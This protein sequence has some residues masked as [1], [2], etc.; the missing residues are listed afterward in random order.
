MKNTSKNI[1]PLLLLFMAAGLFGCAHRGP[2]SAYQG[3]YENRLAD[4]RVPS[5]EEITSVKESEGNVVLGQP[6]QKVWDACLG[7]AAQSKGIL[8]V[9]DDVG[10]VHRLL[11]LSGK[12]VEYKRDLWLFV[13][14]WLAISIRPLA[15]RSTEVRIVFVSPETGRV[16]PFAADRFPRGFK[17]DAKESISQVTGE[18]LIW[19]LTKTF[20]EDDYLSRLSYSKHIARGAPQKIDVKQMEHH[21]SLAQ[22]LGN[23]QSASIRRER[24]VLNEPR[25][26]ERIAAVVRD[27]ARAAGELN[28]ETRIFVI[29][30]ALEAT[31][32]EPNGDVFLTIGT[33]DRIENVDE[34][35]GVLSHELAHLY[36]HH[37]AMR[38]GASRRA[39]ATRN[40]AI[41]IGTLGGAIAGGLLPTKK[42]NSPQAPQDT[43][44]STREV[45]I[46]A[47]V[48]YGAMHF[49]GQIGTSVGVDVGGYTIYRFSQKEELVADNYGAEL[50]WAAGY[51]YRGFLKFLQK[52]N[53]AWLFEAGAKKRR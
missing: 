43:L 9:A 24:F 49:G 35:A 39:A 7:L 45:L 42:P 47:A 10:G 18:D 4:V 17:G 1:A 34:L 31:H 26:E 15:E 6:S 14:R 51:D 32:V 28:R 38:F 30:D 29:A 3:F 33:L 25:L 52:Q 11:L 48:G 41:F 27:I 13:D 46:G 2:R 37:G 22:Q 8:G 12:N 44:L 50:L 40:A 16:A 21:E 36:L 19:A 20:A 53:N 5:Y 23:F